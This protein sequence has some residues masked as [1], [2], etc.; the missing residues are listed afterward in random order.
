MADAKNPTLRAVEFHTV[1][2]DV[3]TADVSSE[4]LIG[5]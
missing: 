1:E 5:R 4:S 3:T 2:W